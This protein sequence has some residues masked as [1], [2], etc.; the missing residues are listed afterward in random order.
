MFSAVLVVSLCSL[1]PCVIKAEAAYAGVIPD[2]MFQ[3]FAVGPTFF[4]YEDSNPFSVP[5]SKHVC[6]SWTYGTSTNFY[7]INVASSYFQP[8]DHAVTLYV[9]LG[10]EQ[11]QT[12]GSVDG[13][14]PS[15]DYGDLTYYT[16]D[17]AR[18][19]LTN[20]VRVR[21]LLNFGPHGK[22]Y[23]YLVTIPAYCTQFSFSTPY[24]YR[25]NASVVTDL[26][27]Y[28][29]YI[30]DTTEVSTVEYFAQIVEQLQQVNAELDTQTAILRAVQNTI[31]SVDSN[32][33]SI[34]DILHTA[35][36]DETTELDRQS[37]AAAEKVMQQDNAEQY[38]NDK[39]QENFEA[40]GFDQ[41]SFD[42][43]V[44][45]ALATVGGL[46]QSL[47]NALGDATIV[48]TFPLIFGLALVVI[49]R[50]ARSEG[51]ARAEAARREA[52]KGGGKGK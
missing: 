33:S 16:G 11:V 23:G 1:L 47:W 4:V 46:F 45:S 31:N 34:Y 7:S 36:A 39:N 28:G 44:S 8:L 2:P 10:Y 17:S 12:K 41:F 32:V 5:N 25:P 52:R 42:H 40:I 19:T 50:T 20:G 30:L 49:G 26:C 9:S 24:K 48:I 51:K 6:Q 22:Y 14:A 37:Q 18:K 27:T 29:S 3:L 35:L 43:P 21:S 13:S 38:W 15:G